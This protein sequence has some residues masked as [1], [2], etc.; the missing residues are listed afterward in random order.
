MDTRPQAIMRALRK[1]APSVE[2]SVEHY[3][4][5]TEVWEGP[6]PNPRDEGFEAYSVTVSASAIWKGKRLT[7]NAYLSGVW[8]K[9]DKIDPD[10]GGYLPQMLELAAKELYI[11]SG[12]KIP[13][14]VKAHMYLERVLAERHQEQERA[15]RG[16]PFRQ[17]EP[18]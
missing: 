10:I 18:E 6:D 15:Y 13:E 1:I 5:P 7:G 4:D 8:E 12:K 16:H 9:P 11:V 14:A 2:F 3:E 17:W